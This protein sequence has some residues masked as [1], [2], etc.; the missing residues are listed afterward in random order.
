MKQD[1]PDAPYLCNL[2]KRCGYVIVANF[3]L[4]MKKE[5]KADNTP[6]TITDTAI[7][8]DVCAAIQ[9]DYPHIRVVGEEESSA[10]KIENP[11]YIILCD[12]V[13]GTIPFSH[14]LPVSTFCIAVLKDGTPLVG[15][16][17][18]PFMKRMWHAERTKGS[19]LG[20]AKVRVSNTTALRHAMIYAA[21]LHSNVLTSSLYNP[22]SVIHELMKNEAITI[23][24][25]SIAYFGGLVASGE[26]DATIYPITHGWETAAM[27]II[28]EEASGK[29]TDIYGN[30]IRYN[31]QGEV[32]GHIISN[33]KVHDKLVELVQKCL[34]IESTGL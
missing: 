25:H 31:P 30:N 4:G 29:A 23:D 13:D 20:S 32:Q 2:A 14:G 34:S 24:M 11:E 21:L 18:D 33:G 19:F 15:V 26:F 7:N 22:L 10:S 27:H 5:W 3:N 16:I 9:R 12:P 28:V 6:L 1:Y 8:S 17:Y